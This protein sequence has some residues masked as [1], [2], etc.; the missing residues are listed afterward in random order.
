M[1]INIFRGQ[2]V[3]WGDTPMQSRTPEQVERLR[4]AVR[5]E[6]E[7]GY[8]G[9]EDR[10]AAFASFGNHSSRRDYDRGGGGYGGGGGRAR[11]RPRLP[12]GV[13]PGE[14]RPAARPPRRAPR[15]GGHGPG[16]RP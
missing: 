9:N 3:F 14:R 11:R 15:P 10:D 8:Q 6:A 16:A 1:E 4:A 7:G 12:D 2:R 5:E 13:S